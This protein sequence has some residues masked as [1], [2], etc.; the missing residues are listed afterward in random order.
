MNAPTHA[1][2]QLAAS[3]VALFRAYCPGEG[4]RSQW[5]GSSYFN[6][7]S[8]P[9]PRPNMCTGQPDLDN[10]SPR[11]SRFKVTWSQLLRQTTHCWSFNGDIFPLQQIWSQAR[12]FQCTQK[13][14]APARMCHPRTPSSSLPIKNSHWSQPIIVIT[15]MM[16]MMSF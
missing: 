9:P 16:M 13:S 4:S 8:R 15:M 14:S 2:N 1:C 3:C 6:Y 5:A 7:Q 11:C 12:S 10:L